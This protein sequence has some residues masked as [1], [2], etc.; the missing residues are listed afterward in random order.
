MVINRASL[1]K[2]QVPNKALLKDRGG[3]YSLNKAGYFLGEG[4]VGWAP[5]TTRI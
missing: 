4:V 3:Q 5:E 2:D 1:L